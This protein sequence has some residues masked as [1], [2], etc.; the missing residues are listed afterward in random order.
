M[1]LDHLEPGAQP[2]LDLTFPEPPDERP[3][4]IVN[5]VGSIDGKAV[6]DGTEQGLSSPPDKHRMQ[7]LR[8]QA[9]A[10]LNGAGT[11]RKSGATSRIDDP[12]LVEWRMRRGKRSAHPL[13]VLITTRAD[14]DRTGDYFDGS[15]LEAVIV[16]S[17]ITAERSREIEE[18]GPR[19]VPVP[20]GEEGLRQAARYLRR[21]RD[22]RLLLVEG[23]PTINDELLRLD[24]VDEFFLTLSPTFVGGRTT[25][26]IVAGPAPFTRRTARRAALISVIANDETNE[27]YLRYRMR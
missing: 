1:E 14:F 8:A 19:V 16:A 25:L 22:V 26:S 11:M 27:L 17:E 21:E 7:E 18:L 15:G 3:Y 13:G 23:G 2:Y 6:L 24:L 12:S 4:I 5:M 20:R 10:V 9:D